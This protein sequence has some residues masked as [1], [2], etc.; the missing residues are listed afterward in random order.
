[1]NNS[2]N[3][4]TTAKVKTAAIPENCRI[5]GFVLG[6]QA[7]TFKVFSILEAIDKTAAAGCKTIEF[8]PGQKFSPDKSMLKFDHNATEAM[9]GVV[10]ARLSERG[11]HAVNYGVV[12]VPVSELGAG[13]IFEF[14][15]E[16]KLYGITTESADAIDII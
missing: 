14:A 7:W 1:M 11:I 6:C 8:Y 2:N 3:S 10:K 12:D 13:K 5:G 4:T 15:K 16:L 9:I